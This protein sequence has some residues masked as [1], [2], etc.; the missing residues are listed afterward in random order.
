MVSRMTLMLDGTPGGFLARRR[1]L[2]EHVTCR[3]CGGH[4]ALALAPSAAPAADAP[5]HQCRDCGFQ[6]TKADALSSVVPG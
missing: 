3:S 5:T 4:H 1:E 2:A 6:W